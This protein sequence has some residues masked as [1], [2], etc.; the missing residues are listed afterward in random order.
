MLS[1]G[2]EPFDHWNDKVCFF[3]T[4]FQ[5]FYFLDIFAMC[6]RNDSQFRVGDLPMHFDSVFGFYHILVAYDDEG[7]RFN[8]FDLFV[9]DV[10]KI[11]HPFHILIEHYLQTI[12]VWGYL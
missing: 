12:R 11:H 8:G 10:F 7:R 4:R 9:G 1:F 2:Q 5:G 6:A 3:G